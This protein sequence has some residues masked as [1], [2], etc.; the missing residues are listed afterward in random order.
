MIKLYWKHFPSLEVDLPLTAPSG[1]PGTHIYLLLRMAPHTF[2]LPQQ[3]CQAWDR[4]L[5]VSPL[6]LVWWYS[7]LLAIYV[8]LDP[9]S[10]E[11]KNR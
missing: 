7:T 4:T 1:S 3:V 10:N 8:T 5:P 9:P 11:L 6:F 2:L